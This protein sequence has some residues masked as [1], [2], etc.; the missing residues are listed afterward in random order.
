VLGF[1]ELAP[2]NVDALEL[3]GD[4]NLIGW[5]AAI[6]L[7]DLVLN[8]YDRGLLLVKL[9]VIATT[10]VEWQEARRREA[11]RRHGG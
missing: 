5:D 11:E 7:R 4:I 10:T 6:A 1:P 9:R 8:D 3:W 2:Q